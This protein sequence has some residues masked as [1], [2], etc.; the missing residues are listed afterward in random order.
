MNRV[1]HYRLV[2]MIICMYSCKKCAHYVRIY[3]CRYVQ[4]YRLCILHTRMY[5][6]PTTSPNTSII[7]ILNIVNI[8][9]WY[10]PNYRID[11]REFFNN[12]VSL[13]FFEN[14]QL[15]AVREKLYSEDDI[16][17]KYQRKNKAQAI[18]WRVMVDKVGSV[19]DRTYQE[20]TRVIHSVSR[21]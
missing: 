15:K 12:R 4:Y 17:G 5:I 2:S 20:F 19:V 7:S 14:K 11:F 21:A 6:I 3:D 1:C 9:Y 18:I 13:P 10:D 16:V 8:S